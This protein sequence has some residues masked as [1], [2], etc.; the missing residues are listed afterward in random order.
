MRLPFEGLTKLQI[1]KLLVL[2]GVHRYKYSKGEEIIPTIKNDNIIGIIL[3]GFA[4]IINI[5]YNGNELVQENLGK[6]S[7]FGTTISATNSESCQ[8]IAKEDT[9]VLIIDYSRLMRPEN[10]THN[11][12]NI[13]LSNLYDIMSNKFRETNERVK[14]LEKKQIR[15]KLLKFFEIEHKKSHSKNIYLNFALKDLADYLAVD[16]S[17]MFRELKHLKDDKLIEVDGRKIK[18]L[19]EI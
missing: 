4:Q 5:E 2:L 3:D 18:I 13:F 15:E 19:Y 17:A 8:I 16:R 12:F 7:V 9:E 6:D 1:S 11:Y 14:V 10:L